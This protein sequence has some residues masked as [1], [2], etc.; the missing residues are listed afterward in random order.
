[1]TNI[2]QWKNTAQVLNWFNSIDNKQQYAF[3]AFDV[4]DFY[5]SI[6]IDLLNKALEF[7]ANYQLISNEEK[8]IILHTK[9]SYLFN[10]GEPCMG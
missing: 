10:S 7:A 9:K 4:V 1:M 2:N 6:T 8:N 3:I 5:P